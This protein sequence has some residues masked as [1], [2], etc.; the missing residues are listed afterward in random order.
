MY[1]Q[2]AMSTAQRLPISTNNAAVL[3]AKALTLYQ[4]LPS[5]TPPLPLGGE[6]SSGTV[7]CLISGRDIALP[8]ADYVH[9]SP[10]TPRS[11]Q[12]NPSLKIA[13][14]TL[15]LSIVFVR[16]SSRVQD[17]ILQGV[18]SSMFLLLRPQHS[19]LLAQQ[20]PEV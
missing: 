18:C 20:L 12:M 15:R 4:Q 5:K 10:P 14:S 2:C 8:R 13:F 7:R 1:V 16:L 11:S 17:V 3:L 6:D 9:K 19:M